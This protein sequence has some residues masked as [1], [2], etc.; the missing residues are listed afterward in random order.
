M[1]MRR[2]PPAP[3][4]YSVSTNCIAN[5][6]RTA[7]FS[8]RRNNEPSEWIAIVFVVYR[9]GGVVN[10]VNRYGHHYTEKPKHISMKEFVIVL[11]AKDRLRGGPV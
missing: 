6:H 9:K 11:C 4:G 8:I 5:R 1:K 3:A 7:L 10:A 2:L